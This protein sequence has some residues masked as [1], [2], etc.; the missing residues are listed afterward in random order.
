MP[1]IRFTAE[2]VGLE[3]S[4]ILAAARKQQLG[5]R[6]KLPDILVL[7][8]KK[9]TPAMNLNPASLQIGEW[10]VD[11]VETIA[12][13]IF[14]ASIQWEERIAQKSINDIFKIELLSQ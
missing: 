13:E 6:A 4:K 7:G 12:A 11:V 14:L 1:A 5:E 10:G 2:S 8:G 3:C 9:T